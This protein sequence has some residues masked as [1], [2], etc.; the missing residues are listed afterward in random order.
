LQKQNSF[1]KNLS[2]SPSLVN[3]NKVINCYFIA[4]LY[5]L[6]KFLWFSVTSVSTIIWQA[7]KMK[8]NFFFSLQKV[9]TKIGTK[10]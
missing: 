4:S 9:K 7:A 3:N 10:T 6:L 1:K 8:F 2:Y 5:R